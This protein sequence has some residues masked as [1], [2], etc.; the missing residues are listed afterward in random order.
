MGALGVLPPTIA[1]HATEHIAEMIAMIE[2]LIETGHAYEADGH[3]LF[4][5]PSDPDYGALGRRDRD[6]M[7]AGARVEVASYKKDPGRFRAVEA[8]RAR[9]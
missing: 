2:R 7:I 6:A 3:V 9:Q 1:P 4:D 5:V 8:V